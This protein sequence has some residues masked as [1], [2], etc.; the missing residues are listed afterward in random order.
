MFSVNCVLTVAQLVFGYVA[1]SLSLM[2]DGALMAIDVVCYAVG[3]WVERQKGSAAAAAN[4][5]KADRLGA[6]FSIILLGATTTWMLFDA[7]D[8]LLGEEDVD[9]RGVGRQQP[10]VSGELMVIFTT[11][12]LLAD[13]GIIVACL[14]CGGG[15]LLGGSDNMNL[16]GALAHLG[17]DIVRGIAV[18]ICGILAVLH[19]ADPLQADA[20]CSLF[21]CL[22]IL[23]ATASILRMLLK[24]SNPSAYATFSEGEADAWGDVEVEPGIDSIPLGRHAKNL[25]LPSKA[26]SAG[27]V[28]PASPSSAA[29]TPET[30]GAQML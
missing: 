17:A 14:R 4:K 23:S 13:I 3:L 25:R 24:R 15:S 5:A 11:I 9:I 16:Y 7:V 12:N 30:F 20:Y 28:S 29:P 21:V 6:F 1:N 19:I 10:K 27:D 8:R 2:G 22:F 18:L 26:S